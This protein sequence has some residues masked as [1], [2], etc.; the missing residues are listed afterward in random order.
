VTPTLGHW[1]RTLR[2]NGAV[3]YLPPQVYAA[4]AP[5]SWRE[6]QRRAEGLHALA[7]LAEAMRPASAVPEGRYG[8][9]RAYG[10]VLCGPG[11]AGVARGAAVP[12]LRLGVLAVN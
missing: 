3:S 2:H 4:G 6:R 8:I 5:L 10:V 11:R 9:M 7:S 12:G 1:S